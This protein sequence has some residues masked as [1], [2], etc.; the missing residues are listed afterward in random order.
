MKRKRQFMAR[1]VWDTIL[2]KYVVP[3][4]D[5]NVHL[6]PPTI[7]PHKDGEPLLNKKYPELLRSI[8]DLDP[9]LKIDIYSH[10]LLLKREFIDYLGTLP[11]NIR[12]LISFHFYNH[13]GTQNDYSRTTRVLWDL[14]HSNEQ[15]KNVEFILASHVVR[16]MTLERLEVWKGI[17]T[18]PIEQGRVTVHANAALN[19]WT[20]LIEEPGTIE[21]HGCPYSEF[22]H[23]FFG[24][25]GNVIACCMDLEEEIVFGNVMK[26][27]PA[28][29]V[30]KVREFYANQ[31]R[32]QRGDAPLV[33]EVCRNCFGLGTRQDTLV[34]LGGVA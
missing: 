23:M 10:G 1:E 20:G 15:P 28:E 4:R 24:A 6:S 29:M 5:L 13:D 25:T 32:I 31:Q 7:I 16:P 17:W 33:H 3:Y 22:G 27:D 9:T 26:D 30:D 18:G 2:H 8:A 21:F 11:N 14:F 19:P 12:L 34:Q